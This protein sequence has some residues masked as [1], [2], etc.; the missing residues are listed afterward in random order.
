MAWLEIETYFDIAVQASGQSQR[1]VE[2]SDSQLQAKFS[3]GQVGLCPPWMPMSQ[4][5]MQATVGPL[6]PRGLLTALLAEGSILFLSSFQEFFFFWL[7]TVL[8]STVS[9]SY[10]GVCYCT[11]AFKNPK[12]SPRRRAAHTRTERWWARGPPSGCLRLSRAGGFAAL[13]TRAGGAFSSTVYRPAAVRSPPTGADS[14][15]RLPAGCRPDRGHSAP[16]VRREEESRSKWKPSRW[17]T[18]VA[19]QRGP[20]GCEAAA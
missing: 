9:N 1:F 7:S 11:T 13:R 2:Q 12:L 20:S 10:S 8:L 4:T 18:G 6:I 17:S 19:C 5:V 16:T 3:F 15:W 14:P